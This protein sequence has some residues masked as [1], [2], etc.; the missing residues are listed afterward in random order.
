MQNTLSTP[1]RPF[2]THG[3]LGLALIAI[4]WPLNWAVTPDIPFTAYGFFPL[5]LGYCLTV[6]ALAAYFHG[7][8]LLTRSLPRYLSL[9]L[10]SAPAWWV[11]EVLNWRLQ[12]WHYVGRELFT[13][14]E[15]LLLSSLSFSTVLPAVLGTAELLSGAGFIREASKWLVLPPTP[16]ITRIFALSGAGMFLAMVIWPR[17]FFPFIWISLYCILEPINIWLGHRALGERTQ[18]GDWRPVL[19]LFLGALTCGF[20]WEMWNFFSF[21]KW[22]YTVP[23]GSFAHVFEMPLLGYG[24][25]LPFALELFAVYHFVVGLLGE[26]QTD[27][28]TIGLFREETIERKA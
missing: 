26:K 16:R 20:F 18:F 14:L 15:Y 5:W 7:T 10:V 2:P 22:V 23:W 17:T 9:F 11:F 19:A 8:S 25:Y 28:V 24:G 4:F 21:P 1:S 27:Y 6:D 3:W 12:N 13:D